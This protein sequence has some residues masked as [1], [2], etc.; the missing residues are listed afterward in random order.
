MSLS[1]PEDRAGGTTESLPK[2]K[3]KIGNGE[4]PALNF[5]LP[6]ENDDAMVRRTISQAIR[7][8]SKSRE[9]I[10]DEM[11]EILGV[12]VTVS[13]LNDFTASAKRLCRW[14]AAWDRAFCAVTGDHELLICRVRAAGFTVIGPVERDL[15]E[16]GREYLRRKRADA[17][18]S[19]LEHR[20]REV[21]L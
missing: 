6:A 2:F 4:Q 15:L 11:T 20:L 14:P 21:K 3:E 17:A 13:M 1:F 12:R 5:G 16:L 7:D 8:C 10:A 18:T 9:Q 19:E